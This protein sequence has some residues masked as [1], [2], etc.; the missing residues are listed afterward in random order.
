MSKLSGF[1]RLFLSTS[2]IV[3]L[4]LVILYGAFLMA[5]KGTIPSADLLIQHLSSLYTRFGYEVVF[6]GAFLEAL[7]MI[8]LF[9]P[10]ATAAGL[11]AVF[12][13]SGQLDLTFVV[14]AASLGAILGYL[15]DYLLG[16]FGIGMFLQ[17]FKI[18]RKISG[19][20]FT[21]GFIHTSTGSVIALSSGAFKMPLSLFLPLMIF[22]TLAWVCLWGLLIFALG[23]VFLIILLKYAWVLILLAISVWALTYV[24]IK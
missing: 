2:I 18:N 12:A 1:F 15:I 21:L 8:N 11:G 22:S 10:G 5:V 9:V 20:T 24:Y 23:E 14:L 13:R 3:P 4:I 19:K 6:L 17:K 16:Y 7:V